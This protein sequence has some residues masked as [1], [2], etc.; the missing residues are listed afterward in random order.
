MI[1][2]IHLGIHPIFGNIQIETKKTSPKFNS[3]PLKIDDWK[4]IVFLLG[5]TVFRGELL[6][7]RGVLFKRKRWVPLG[8]GT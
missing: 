4:T 7:F 8:R 1:F 2:T 5:M 3:S 6:N